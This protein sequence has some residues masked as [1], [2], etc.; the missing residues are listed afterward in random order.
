MV[1]RCFDCNYKPGSCLA[2]KSNYAIKHREKID[3]SECG[4][5][6]LSGVCVNYDCYDNFDRDEANAEAS[7]KAS[8]KTNVKTVV[9]TSVKT[10]KETVLKLVQGRD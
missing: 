6:V 9:K 2:I 10:S 1:F 7:A 8:A 3:K 5:K 4:G